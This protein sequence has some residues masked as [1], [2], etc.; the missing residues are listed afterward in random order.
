[1]LLNWWVVGRVERRAQGEMGYNHLTAP[2]FLIY[3]THKTKD[4]VDFSHRVLVSSLKKL[5]CVSVHL[6]FRLQYQFLRT[7]NNNQVNSLIKLIVAAMCGIDFSY[8][9]QFIGSKYI[10]QF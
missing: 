8:A 6:N 4:L 3:T 2:A 9:S 1:M 5:R 10:C 7:H